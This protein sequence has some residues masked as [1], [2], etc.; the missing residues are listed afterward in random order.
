MYLITKFEHRKLNII[1]GL[2]QRTSAYQKARTR[3]RSLMYYPSFRPW[4]P[5][6][7]VSILFIYLNPTLFWKCYISNKYVPRIILIHP[8]HWILWIK[9]TYFR[10]APGG[11]CHKRTQAVCVVGTYKCVLATRRAQSYHQGRIAR[12]PYIISSLRQKGFPRTPERN[13]QRPCKM[14]KKKDPVRALVIG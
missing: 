6:T 10:A 13:P 12:G 1:P 11:Q 3:C 5:G 9:F 7:A 8:S 4:W 14:I 2:R